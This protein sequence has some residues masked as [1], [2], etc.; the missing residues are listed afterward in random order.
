MKKLICA[1]VVAGVASVAAIGAATPA[2]AA[3]GISFNLGGI[4]VGYT[5]GY[6]DHYHHW[7]RWRRGEWA[8][9]RHAHPHH[10]YGWRHDDR[11]H[12]H[13]WHH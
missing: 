4:D 5:D 6:Y 11:R 13:G 3:V 10:A 2:S 9:Y 8:A 1:A 7:H 12:H